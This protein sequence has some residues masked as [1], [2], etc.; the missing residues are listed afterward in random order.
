MT[1]VG[2]VRLKMTLRIRGSDIELDFTGSDP[3]V[4]AALNLPSWSHRGHWS[5]VIGLVNYMRTVD[6]H[7]PYNSGLVRPI[8][9]IAPKGTIVNPEP[10][11]ACG[12]RAATQFRILDMTI[13]T[14]GRIAPAIIPAAGA[15]Q[16]S[17]ALVA[18]PD[19]ADG[20]LKVSVLQ[21]LVGG[22]GGRPNKDGIEAGDFCTF[23]RNIP[24]E[25]LE[26]DLPIIVHRYGLRPDSAGPGMYRGGSGVEFS[27]QLLSP[28]AT[29]TARGLERYIFAPWGRRGGAPGVTGLT[30]LTQ[31]DGTTRDD[32]G[33]ITVLGLS[34]GET[35]TFRTQGGGGFGDPFTRDP[36][37]V[38]DDVIRGLVS[39]KMAE[40]DYGVVIRNGE[41][42]AA[43]T[44][45]IRNRPR[46]APADPE[47][48]LGAARE[49]YDRMWPGAVQD[50]LNQL[51]TEL[52]A[53]LRPTART[54]MLKDLKSRAPDGSITELDVEAAY[55][56]LQA[57]WRNPAAV[58]VT[59]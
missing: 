37:R 36:E 31:P 51:L 56:A 42:D 19:I 10:P 55:K 45:E 23:L 43:A 57:R 28:V 40:R 54:F 21:P 59:A 27:F 22:S 15:G 8:K 39:A 6:P 14:L 11:A 58:A 52:P 50:R 53:R 32:V 1:D 38:R 20:E 18:T 41:V 13:A 9:L 25:M 35:L 49:A 47:Y 24:N 30:C 33:K 16:M 26:H 44:A 7:V 12:V 46:P 4:H 2:I 48:T 34:Q 29:V 3:Q 5:F 17:I